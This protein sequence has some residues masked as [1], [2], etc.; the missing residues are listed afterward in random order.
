MNT[1]KKLEIRLENIKKE[2]NK[3]EKIISELTQ[4]NNHLGLE[5]KKLEKIHQKMVDVQREVDEVLG[6][7]IELTK[8]ED[9]KEN[10]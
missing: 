2:I 3:N 5:A 7:K 6:N 10:G 1:I 9:V 8:A 4:K